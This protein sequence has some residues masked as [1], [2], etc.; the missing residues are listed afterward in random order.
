MDQAAE[1]GRKG[2]SQSRYVLC[3]SRDRGYSVGRLLCEVGLPLTVF[4]RH[5][6]EMVL[7]EE[8]VQNHCPTQIVRLPIERLGNVLIDVRRNCDLESVS[9]K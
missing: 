7:P 6:D 5:R 8:S 9:W 4:C 2:N 3:D 1:S